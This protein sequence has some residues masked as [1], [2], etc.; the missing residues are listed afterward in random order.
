VLIVWAARQIVFM[1]ST[2]GREDSVEIGSSIDF[3]IL[4]PGSGELAPAA[5][6]RGPETGGHM[7]RPVPR[8]E[9]ADLAA[10]PWSRAGGGRGAAAPGRLTAVVLDG[11]QRSPAR[12]R[13]IHMETPTFGTRPRVSATNT[14]LVRSSR[15]RAASDRVQP[16]VGHSA[17]GLLGGR[18]QR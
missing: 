4:K 16:V 1:V 3:L 9:G 2:L 10:R 13:L 17:L 14:F 8:R 7:G 15:G 12:Q 6:T 11:L 18:K 5:R